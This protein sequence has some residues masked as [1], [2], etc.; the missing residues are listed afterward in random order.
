MKYVVGVDFSASQNACMLAE[1]ETGRILRKKEVLRGAFYKEPNSP[2]DSPRPLDCY[3][4]GLP[5]ED[6]AHAYLAGLVQGFLNDAGIKKSDVMAVGISLAGKL[7][8]DGRDGKDVLFMGANT[9]KRFG[10]TESGRTSINATRTLRKEFRGIP[11][12]GGND[13]NCTGIAQSILYETRGIGPKKT[14]YLTISTG[15]GGGGPKEDADEIGHMVIG[16]VHPAVS[17]KCGCG[18]QDCLEAY[19]SGTGISNFAKKIIWLYRMNPRKFAGYASYEREVGRLLDKNGRPFNLKEAAVKSMLAGMINEKQR[20]GEAFT[21]KDVFKAMYKKD[22]LA[23]HILNTT[24][25]MTAEVI[26]STAQIHDLERVGIGGGVGANNP[27]YVGMIQKHVNRILIKGNKMLPK[28]VIVEVCPL[29]KAA[30]DYGAL[31]LAMP[32]K[33]RAQWAK[34]MLKATGKKR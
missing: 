19:A 25:R 4:P 3:C 14:F 29:G 24:A 9:P 12:I 13:C 16:N 10:K 7:F 23:Y 2:D 34:T 32:E 11:I 30:N 1:Y 8:S 20:K 27:K 28:G 18:V 26:A 21:A 6:R 33:Y 5:V 15:I 17:L 31:S 22:L